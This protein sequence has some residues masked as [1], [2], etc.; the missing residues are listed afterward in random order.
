MIVKIFDGTN[1]IDAENQETNPPTCIPNNINTIKFTPVKTQKVRI[2]FSRDLENDYYVGVTEIE[3]WATFPQT[4]KPNVYEAEDAFI[5]GA[6]IKESLSAS[7]G[8]FVGEIDGET[9]MVEF[10]GIWVDAAGGYNIRVFYA[11]AGNSDATMNVTINRNHAE[12]LAFE[13]TNSSWGNFDDNI[14]FNYTVPLLRGNNNI[15][16]KHGVNYAELDKIQID[17]P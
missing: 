11:N 6:S 4:P 14:Y 9:S 7:S 17:V 12:V 8:S 1:W 10:F 5:T 2:E 15:V 13:P 16:F 3:I